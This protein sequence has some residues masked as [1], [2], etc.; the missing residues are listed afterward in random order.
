MISSVHVADLH[1][2]SAFSDDD[3]QFVECQSFTDSN[4][5]SFNTSDVLMKTVGGNATITKETEG[6]VSQTLDAELQNLN[7]TQTAVG[8]SIKTEAQ[9][10]NSTQTAADGT[11]DIENQSLNSSAGPPADGTFNAGNQSLNSTQTPA[12]GTFNAGNQSLNSTQTPAD[13]TFDH[14]TQSLNSTATLDQVEPRVSTESS[15][16]FGSCSAGSKSVEDIAQHD[17]DFIE[18]EP[19]L[20][21]ELPEEIRCMPSDEPE[22]RVDGN[23]TQEVCDE[24]VP[25]SMKVEK[26]QEVTTSEQPQ[27]DEF[28]PEV[29]VELAKP[30]EVP[31][32]EAPAPEAE[33]YFQNID[34]I[35]KSQT[36]DKM[37]ATFAGETKHQEI[38]KNP[39]SPVTRTNEN[40]F[41]DK[42]QS[43]F[44]VEFKKPAVPVFKQSPA[45]TFA[46]DEF[47]CGSSCKN[48][49]RC[50]VR[51]AFTNTSKRCV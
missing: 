31:E 10:L 50:C 12:D 29:Q 34:D 32:Q 16:N 18:S 37:E 40:V 35:S 23:V 19:A 27:A 8:E 17:S 49:E 44:D 48:R 42:V 45:E 1:G 25:I 9:N 11:F 46:D 20:K 4:R 38:E 24:S 39:F 22:K 26:L 28:V 30:V 36:A 13:G 5:P 41:F 15:D 47:N 3:E 14:G 21:N 33:E 7:S 6:D 2:T 51:S 43:Q